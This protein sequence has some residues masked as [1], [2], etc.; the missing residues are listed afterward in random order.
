MPDRARWRIAL[1]LTLP[2]LGRSPSIFMPALFLGVLGAYLRLSGSPDAALRV[3][4]ALL[5]HVLLISTQD[6]FKGAAAR[7]DFE[8]VLFVRGGFRRHALWTS[9]VLALAGTAYALV[10]FALAGGGAGDLSGFLAALAAGLYYVGLGGLLGHLARGGSNVLL[11]VV[12]QAGAFIGLVADASGGYRFLESLTTGV[13]DTAAG[14]LKLCA[15]AAVL[16]NVLV[17]LPLRRYA[18]WLVPAAAGLFL[19]Q[20]LAARRA[21]TG[22]R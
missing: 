12:A 17:A 6:A 21:E 7:G 19:A 1:R 5:P 4:L 3:T 22:A 10:S 20:A 16:P 18:F 2:K 11:V 13:F 9:L 14:R 15:L 8:S